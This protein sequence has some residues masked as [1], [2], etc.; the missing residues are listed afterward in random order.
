[1]KT[2]ITLRPLKY[3]KDYRRL[4]LFMDE[5]RK[6][7]QNKEVTKLYIDLGHGYQDVVYKKT[8]INKGSLINKA[9]ISNWLYQNGFTDNECHLD[10]ELEIIGSKH[11]FKLI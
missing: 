3:G 5:Y 9:L 10:F 6:Y 2:K 11:Y 8:Y 4:G 7:V 1:M